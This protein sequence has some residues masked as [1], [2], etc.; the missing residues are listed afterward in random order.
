MRIQDR[1]KPI[2]N[3]CG[4]VAPIDEKLSTPN[5]TVY[6]LNE[7]CE[8]GGTYIMQLQKEQENND[9]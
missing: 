9:D 7:K 3:K 6:R 1:V 2:C 5:W 8:C 4:K